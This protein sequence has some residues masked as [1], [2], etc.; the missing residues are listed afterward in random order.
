MILFITYLLNL[1]DLAMTSLWVRLYGIEAEANPIGRWLFESNLS[2]VV[3]I[4][5]VGGLLAVLGV[6]IHK[7]PQNAWTAF[8]PL[9]AYGLIA[10]YHVAIYFY[11]K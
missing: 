7:H 1:F 4:F 6:C 10:V 11:I 5:A 3:K 2:W 8:I 9:V